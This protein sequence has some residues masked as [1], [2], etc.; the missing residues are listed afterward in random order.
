MIQY[1]YKEPVRVCN[2]CYRHILKKEN[3]CL[4]KLIPYLIKIE[5]PTNGNIYLFIQLFNTYL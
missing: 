2:S 5:N 4:S 3:Q 1:D